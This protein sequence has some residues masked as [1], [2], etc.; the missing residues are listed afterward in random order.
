MRVINVQHPPITTPEKMYGKINRSIGLL[1]DLIYMP[2]AI[3]NWYAVALYKAGLKNSLEI[4]LRDGGRIKIKS[5]D[6]F[7]ETLGACITRDKLNKFKTRYQ[8]SK[9][10][11]VIDEKV[12]L[13]YE[14]ELDLNNVLGSTLAFCEVHDRLNQLKCRNKVVIDIGA[15]IGDTA[16]WFALHGAKHVI[17]LEPYPKCH[18]KLCDNIAASE[19]QDK[20]TAINAALGQT[21]GIIKL[22][23]QYQSKAG[24]DIKQSE[25]GID[26]PTISLDT[27][28]K[29]Y[30]IENGVLKSNSEGG[31]YAI[32]NCRKDT[33]RKFESI[34]ID[35]HYGC[36]PLVKFLKNCGFKVKY[37]T[38]IYFIDNAAIDKN[39]YMGVIWA[40]RQNM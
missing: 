6:E 36:K 11:V 33:I 13:L 24:S 25:N 40:E 30:E 3:E 29:K 14:N 5:R 18:K 38:P 31:E 4:K 39:M 21:D 22:D 26:I 7:T 19:M 8:I 27:L 16:M 1:K 17:A 2:K 9:N 35:Y 37:T 20:I 15:Y 32:L 10:R 28:A 34:F 23:P 12:V